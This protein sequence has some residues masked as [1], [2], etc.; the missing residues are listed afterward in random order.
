MSKN[1]KTNIFLFFFYIF[2]AV[3]IAYSIFSN[4]ENNNE[5]AA[6]TETPPKVTPVKLNQ[7]GLNVDS[8]ISDQN[9]IKRNQTLSDLLIKY[10]LNSSTINSIASKSKSIF[11]VKK[12]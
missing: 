11:D 7:F 9:Q 12:N 4:D 8:L 3:L 5:L 10:N 2:A 1:R 6:A